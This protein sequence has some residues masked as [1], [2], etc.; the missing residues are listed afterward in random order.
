M[1]DQNRKRL[2][3][4]ILR[5]IDPN[6]PLLSAKALLRRL[7]LQDA[8]RRGD[9]VETGEEKRLKRES[10]L[11]GQIKAN[12]GR[13][14]REGA[15]GAA[16]PLAFAGG[17]VG[18][19]AG[20]YLAL[21]GI[22]S[23]I[24]DPSVGNVAMAGLGALPFIGPAGRAMKAGKAA[25]KVGEVERFM[26]NV[27][28]GPAAAARPTSARGRVAYA[29][30]ETPFNPSER[31]MPNKPGDVTAGVP[32]GP[33]PTGSA[34]RYMP[35]VGGAVTQGVEG[36]NPALRGL[37]D[38]V[39]QWMPNAPGATSQGVAGVDDAFRSADD[40]VERYMPN[41]TADTPP[42][43]AE[44]E[45][46]ALQRF[47]DQFDTSGLSMVDEGGPML[48]AS[49]D[50]AA[51]MEALSRASG[52]AGRGETFGVYD[53]AGK[54]RKLIGPDAVDY[55]P[56]Q[57][58]TY[59]VLEAGGNFRT[60]TDMGGRVTGGGAAP[61]AKALPPGDF[62]HAADNTGDAFGFPELPE[63]SESELARIQG[64]FKRLAGR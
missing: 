53:R 20:G 40:V 48:N 31:H 27:P 26:P 37:D 21:D 8:Q 10:T 51:S 13:T 16:L 39:E 30:D 45:D 22:E 32:Q 55:N 11:T 36:V 60:L 6:D 1:P 17:P 35:N 54:F 49:G 23:A 2:E 62:V 47:L 34:D 28:S 29:A 3:A 19:A 24:K 38:I 64:V 56:R 63:I 58:E 5:G 46:A 7:D 15:M 59:G 4:E 9:N 12:P 44:G 25:T 33:M 61:A 14:I 52:M 43:P 50:S 41:R 18:M 57:G 42:L